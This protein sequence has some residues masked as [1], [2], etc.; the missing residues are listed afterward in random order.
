MT[1]EHGAAI[2]SNP[3]MERRDV[4]PSVPWTSRPE[5]VRLT[6]RFAFASL[7]RVPHSPE[8]VGRA[9]DRRPRAEKRGPRR[10]ACRATGLGE[11]SPGSPSPPAL[12]EP[13][14]R[15]GA[16]ARRGVRCARLRGRCVRP[17]HPETVRP[18][19]R[20]ANMI[21]ARSNRRWP[22]L[23]AADSIGGVGGGGDISRFTWANSPRWFQP[24][25]HSLPRHMLTEPL[26]P[27]STV[28]SRRSV[29]RLPRRS[30]RRA[31]PSTSAAVAG[32]P[33]NRLNACTRRLICVT[34]SPSVAGGRAR[35][36]A[37]RR[38]SRTGRVWCRRL[39]PD[40]RG[41]ISLFD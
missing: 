10:A 39:Q 27:D 15:P 20:T 22:D 1:P 34:S 28:I 13:P 29:V 19:I 40:A 38:F 12:S 16:R 9:H 6:V 3:N 17:A 5:V 24:I 25:H 35:A 18:C 30:W 33:W 2:G 31:M 8:R 7:E 41:R 21:T 11:R 26:Y 36:A 37:R 4:V 14:A 32:R 23:N